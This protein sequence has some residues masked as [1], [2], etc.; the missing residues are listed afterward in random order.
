MT[1]SD[2]PKPSRSAAL[3]LL[4][5]ILALLPGCDGCSW[6]KNALTP[7]ERQKLAEEAAKKKEEEAPP[8]APPSQGVTGEVGTNHGHTAE[9]TGAQLS[10]GGAL[11][12][13]ITGSS[14]HPHTV[15]LTAADVDQIANGQ[16]VSKASSTDAGH[17]HT[18]TFN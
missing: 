8:A 7:E 10:A 6:R 2:F 11:S 1:N 5:V 12:L 3:L 16:R 9:I 18:V 15:D 4:V 17:T 13:D 14:N